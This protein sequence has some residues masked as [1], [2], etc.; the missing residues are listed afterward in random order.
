VPFLRSW[1]T[2]VTSCWRKQLSQK[3]AV[4]NALRSPRV[5]AVAGLVDDGDSPFLARHG[6]S[7]L[8]SIYI[9]GF[10]SS[11]LPSDPGELEAR[12]A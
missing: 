3:K 1:E 6:I 10:H 12:P 8:G 2:A 5:C 11:R 4:R 7:R 9:N